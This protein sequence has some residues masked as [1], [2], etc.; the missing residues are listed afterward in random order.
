MRSLRILP[1]HPLLFYNR[2]G[3]VHRF[4]RG[5]HKRFP[6]LRYIYIGVSRLLKE[7]S[8]AL[9]REEQAV[10][11]SDYLGLKW[12]TYQIREPTV[13]PLRTVAWLMAGS[14]LLNGRCPRK[15]PFLR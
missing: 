14:Q 1:E 3:V 9:Y 5:L 4:R 11:E 7:Q 6:D 13:V 15:M 8:I 12:D 2:V 10:V